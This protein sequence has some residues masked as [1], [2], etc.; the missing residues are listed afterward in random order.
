MI[1]ALGY[2]PLPFDMSLEE[3]RQMEYNGVNTI[4]S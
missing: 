2:I 4:K 3:E 1:F